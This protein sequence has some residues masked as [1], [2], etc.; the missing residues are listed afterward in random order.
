MTV[1][2]RSRSGDRDFGQK[3]EYVTEGY[4]NGN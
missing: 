1:N 2:N 4:E 3:I